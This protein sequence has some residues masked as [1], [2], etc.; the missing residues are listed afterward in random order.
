MTRWIL[1]PLLAVASA[2]FV[3]GQ[4]ATATKPTVSPRF[5]HVDVYVDTKGSPLGAYQL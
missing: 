1:M 4:P 3:T 5:T 2:A